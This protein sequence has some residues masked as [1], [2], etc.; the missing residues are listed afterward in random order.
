[1]A[2]AKGLELDVLDKTAAAESVRQLSNCWIVAETELWADHH[3][4]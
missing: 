3:Q 4:E 2:L 1:M